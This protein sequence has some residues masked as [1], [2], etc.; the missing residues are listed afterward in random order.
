[1]IK[2]LYEKKF[3][4]STLRPFL[5]FVLLLILPLLLFSYPLFA[6]NTFSLQ[7]PAL[8]SQTM[9]PVQYTC[10]GRD[11]SPP[12]KWSHPPHN[13]V[14]F[15]LIIS[16]PDAPGGTFYHWVLYNIPNNIHLLPEGIATI[17]IRSTVGK[18]SWNKSSYNGPCPPKGALHHYLFTLYALDK[19]LV[20]P[21]D[22][23]VNAVL[24][25]IKAHLIQQTSM[26]AEYTR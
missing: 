8:S 18:N 17:R 25:Q 20:L 24:A 16:D 3:C 19:K 2:L 22:S 12:L 7:S 4:M 6:A 5:L 11:I 10:D 21:N 15:A 23:D 14:A 9:M 13:T 1:M 26:I